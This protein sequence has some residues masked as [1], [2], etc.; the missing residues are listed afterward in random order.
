M[1]QPEVCHIAG[2]IFDTV[3]LSQRK[4]GRCHARRDFRCVS[5]SLFPQRHPEDV[6]STRGERLFCFGGEEEMGGRGGG[7]P[8]GIRY[9][10][11]VEVVSSCPFPDHPSLSL[12]APSPGAGEREIG[13]SRAAPP[14]VWT[15]CRAVTAQRPNLYLYRG[16]HEST[17]FSPLIHVSKAYRFIEFSPNL[18]SKFFTPCF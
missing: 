4:V 8:H 14:S 15:Y 12:A 16:A 10:R 18:R 3:P 13:F 7:Y 11:K 1:A 17:Y 6:E 2:N 9:D 5:F